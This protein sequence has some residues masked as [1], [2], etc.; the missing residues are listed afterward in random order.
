MPAHG[1]NQFENNITTGC[2][3]ISLVPTVPFFPLITTGQPKGNRL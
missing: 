3:L 1:A 2:V